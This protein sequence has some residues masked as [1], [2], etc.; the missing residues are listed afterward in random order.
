M[1][2]VSHV[3]FEL[4]HPSG[5][6]HMDQ[7]SVFAHKAS[8]PLHEVRATSSLGSIDR[9]VHV[10]P[11]KVGFLGST[12]IMLPNIWRKNEELEGTKD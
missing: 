1:F 10:L 12:I 9:L 4:P 2:H 6:N 3:R 7:A 11:P 8:I 5:A